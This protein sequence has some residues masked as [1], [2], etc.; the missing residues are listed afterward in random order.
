MR[1]FGPNGD[2]VYQRTEGNPAYC[3]FAGGEPDCNIWHFNEHSYEWPSGD[4]IQSGQHRL[5]ATVNAEDGR[6]STI[7]LDFYIP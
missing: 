3:A 1:I 7:S 5:E 6:R 2:E 4:S